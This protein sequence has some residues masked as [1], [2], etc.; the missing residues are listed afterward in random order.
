MISNITRGT[1]F[2]GLLDYS[3]NVGSKRIEGKTAMLIGGNMSGST[4]DELA[5]EFGL[6]RRLRPDIKKPVWHQSLRSVEGENISPERWNDIASSHMKKLGYSEKHPYVIVQHVGEEH[7]H[8][9]ASRIAI[10]GAL[11]YGKN[12]HL[13]ASRDC[14]RIENEFGLLQVKGPEYGLGADG[15]HRIVSP[16]TSKARLRSNEIKMKARTGESPPR[17]MLQKII[18]NC[19]AHCKSLEQYE[20]NLQRANIKYRKSSNGYSYE[21]AGIAF[22]GSQLGKRFSYAAIT[23]TIELNSLFSEKQRLWQEVQSERRR[24]WSHANCLTGR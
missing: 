19:V 9:V 16:A 24:A 6:V 14:R 4:V 22:K 11:Y 21:Y 15:V 1:S 7:I 12:E 17:E 5:W 3:F 23:Q 8:I 18:T 20:L 10:N 2:K 13:I